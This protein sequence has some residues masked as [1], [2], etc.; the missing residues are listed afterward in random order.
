MRGPPQVARKASLPQFQDLFLGEGK[1][2]VQ[3]S[4]GQ[5]LGTMKPF[6]P[7]SLFDLKKC[8]LTSNRPKKSMLRQDKQLDGSDWELPTQSTPKTSWMVQLLVFSFPL[9]Q[10]ARGASAVRERARASAP[11][12]RRG[13]TARSGAFSARRPGPCAW[14]TSTRARGP[15]PE[16]GVGGLGGG[17]VGGGGWAGIG[18]GLDFSGFRVGFWV[19]W[20]WGGVRGLGDFR[21][22]F[23][24]HTIKSG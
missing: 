8:T 11:G 19:G 6:K 5:Y 9:G 15:R 23:A 21:S 22:S 1:P 18:L 7:F 3:T 14:R 10:R 24:G 20:V 4:F 2:K 13:S 16:G 17:G 12:E